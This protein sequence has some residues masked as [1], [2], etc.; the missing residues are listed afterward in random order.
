ME[1]HVS[2]STDVLWVNNAVSMCLHVTMHLWE[3]VTERFMYVPVFVQI[4]ICSHVNMS[5][6]ARTHVCVLPCSSHPY[7]MP[8]WDGDDGSILYPSTCWY[9]HFPSLAGDTELNTDTLVPK[10]NSGN[11]WSPSSLNLQPIKVGTS[12]ALFY[13]LRCTEVE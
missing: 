7:S 10:Q 13:F 5:F 1:M 8:A 12:L 11:I 3:C 2:V 9:Y 6:Y 4:H